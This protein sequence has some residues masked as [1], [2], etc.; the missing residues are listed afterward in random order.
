MTVERREAVQAGVFVLV[1]L[2]AF[3]LFLA[4]LLGRHLFRDVYTYTTI[5][6]RTI[7]G[8]DPG[9][10]VKYLGVPAGKVTDIRFL[11]GSFP[12]V[13]VTMDIAGHVPITEST[14]ATLE[15]QVLTGVAHIELIGGLEGEGRIEPGDRIE[16]QASNFERISK[17]LPLVAEGLPDL[18]ARMES[19][20]ANIE[21]F[22]GPETQERVGRA[23][24]AVDGGM[25]AVEAALDRAS[26]AIGNEARAISSTAEVEMRATGQSA[27]ETLAGMR[28]DLARTLEEFRGVFA[29]ADAQAAW[30]DLQR[31]SVLLVSALE[32]ADGALARVELVLDDDVLDDLRRAVREASELFGDLG[33]DPGRLLSDPPRERRIPDP[34]R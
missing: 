20:V 13:Q 23:L 14:R 11:P 16:S 31:S 28:T 30:S 1:S 7:A 19:A 33:R 29:G 34:D 3:V 8:L 10:D 22:F 18:L 15:I 4:L 26:S 25:V 21:T 27:R 24:E 12:N 2:S 6:D 32:R 9:A 5:F 17:S